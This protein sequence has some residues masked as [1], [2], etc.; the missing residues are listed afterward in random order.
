[1]TTRLGSAHGEIIIDSSGARLGIDRTKDSLTNM[2]S[3]LSRVGGS[4]QGFG[5]SATV[6]I[7][8]PL[9]LIT[10][11]L[12]NLGG[13]LEQTE[14]AFNTLTGSAEAGQRVIEDLFEF[15]AT[16]PFQFDAV[17][18][19]GRKLIAFNGSAETVTTEL[20]RVGDVAAGVQ[21]PISEIAEIYGKAR[22][23]E[24]LFAEDINQLTGRGIPIISELAK[25]FGVA[26]SEIRNL[27]EQGKVGFPELEKAFISMTDEGGKFAGLMEAQSQTVPGLLSTLSDNINLIATDLGTRLIDAFN[28]KEKLQGTITFLADFKD[29]LATLLDENPRLVAIAAETVAFATAI[30][31]LSIAVGTL[32]T[33]IPIFTAGLG[34]VTAALTG[35]LVAGLAVAA[36][37][38]FAF[39]T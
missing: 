8:A 12:I 36:G 30:G 5:R 28:I 6:G 38:V 18:D 11:R 22:V 33:L 3:T 17:A 10:T 9:G 13:Q 19:A 4:M 37:A 34:I 31:P 21:A 16:T 15:T 35:P 20:R 7:S 26:D 32:V 23:Q 2:G 39:R 14:V 25:Q 24:R 1:M 27:V 29:R